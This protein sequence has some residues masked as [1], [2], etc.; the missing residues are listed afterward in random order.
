MSREVRDQI[1]SVRLTKAEKVRLEA[2]GGATKVLREALRPSGVLSMPT[3]GAK[4]R[5]SVLQ[6][7]IADLRQGQIPA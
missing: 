6:A 7:L 2:L 1:V 3:S 4:L 5:G